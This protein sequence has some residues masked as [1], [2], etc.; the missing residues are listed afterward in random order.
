MLESYQS[1]LEEMLQTIDALAFM[2]LSAH[3]KRHLSDKGKVQGSLT[4]HTTHQEIANDLQTSMVVVPR[5]LR[6]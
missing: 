2:D 4:L 5:L 1:Q 6:V 3:L